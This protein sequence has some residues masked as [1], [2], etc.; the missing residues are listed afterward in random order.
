MVKRMM[1]SQLQS[2][3]EGAIGKIAQSP[4]THKA[5]QGALQLK[6]R[7]EKLVRGL[8]DIEGRV[9]ALEKRVE[10]LES[11]KP[12]LTRST[13]GSSKTKSTAK[14]PSSPESSPAQPESASGGA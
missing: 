5:F 2:V 3:G 8:E 9:S 1:F 11:A 13:A 10:K 4:T 14:K 6:E 7:V 12:K